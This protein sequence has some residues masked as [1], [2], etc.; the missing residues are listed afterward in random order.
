MTNKYNVDY[1]GTGNIDYE[2]M[3]YESVDPS[4]M[5]HLGLRSTRRLLRRIFFRR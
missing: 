1:N 2:G 4:V 3:V 5:W